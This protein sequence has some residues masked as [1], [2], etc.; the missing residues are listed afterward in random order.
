MSL[1]GTIIPDS[2]NIKVPENVRV[3]RL[4]TCVSCP[5]NHLIKLT[6]N[7]SQCLCFVREKVELK[8]EECPK[9][10]WVK[11]NNQ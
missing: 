6:G 4:K 10:F 7:C 5:G 3:A 9:K 1:L 8:N 11:Y 2:W